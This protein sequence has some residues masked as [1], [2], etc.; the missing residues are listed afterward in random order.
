MISRD[1]LVHMKPLVQG[2]LGCELASEFNLVYSFF[3]LTSHSLRSPE[4]QT[5]PMGYPQYSKEVPIHV[6]ED[7]R[8]QNMT[9]SPL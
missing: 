2:L 5:D 8:R 9:R 7:L 4:N 3:T 1:G 6:D